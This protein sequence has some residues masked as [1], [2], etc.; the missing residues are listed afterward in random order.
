MSMMMKMAIKALS[1]QL[2]KLGGVLD[3]MEQRF[4]TSKA[5]LVI[6]NE[7]NDQTSKMEPTL[8]L[9]GMDAGKMYTLR[10]KTNTTNDPAGKLQKFGISELGTLIAGDNLNE[11]EE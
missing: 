1:P 2:L 11:D 8:R 6:Q 3:N 4:G 5:M 7:M 9:M 10:D